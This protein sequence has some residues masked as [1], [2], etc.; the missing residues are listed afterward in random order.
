MDF[1][2]D[3]RFFI[4]LLGGLLRLYVTYLLMPILL[5]FLATSY[6]STIEF[7]TGLELASELSTLSYGTF[8]VLASLIPLGL[9]YLWQRQNRCLLL[10][11]LILVIVHIVTLE[12]I[13]SMPYLPIPYMV[14]NA[15]KISELITTIITPSTLA[16]VSLLALNIFHFLLPNK[17][18][19]PY[20]S[21]L[22]FFLIT[23]CYFSF[24]SPALW[25][26]VGILTISPTSTI[27][28]ADAMD[29]ILYSVK[30][31]HFSLLFYLTP[32]CFFLLA[33]FWQPLT[34]FIADKISQLRRRRTNQLETKNSSF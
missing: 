32:F 29:F 21:L 33:R 27:V 30:T 26:M 5:F 19:K 12:F 34:K 10:V 24:L 25:A 31:A 13:E 7:G 28:R 18:T 8:L 1:R 3:K 9:T 4:H 6:D 14:D 2:I 16:L 11:S 15:F 23:N 20:L 17:F 22:P